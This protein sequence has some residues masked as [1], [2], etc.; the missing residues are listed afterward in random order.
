MTVPPLVSI[1]MPNYNHA[2][3]LPLT[4]AAVRAQDYAYTEIVFVDD[5]STDGSAAVAAQLGVTVRSTPVNGGPSLARN[6]G[7]AAAKGEILL[8]VDSDV[9]LP[10]TTVTDAVA[11]LRADPG[12]GAICGMLDA[13]PLVRD[14]LVQECRCLQAHYWRISSEGVVSFLFTAL[15][16]MRTDV[17]VEMGPFDERLRETEEVEYG[18]RLS[19]RYP[20]RLTSALHGRHRDEHRMLPLLSKVFRRCRLRVPLYARRRRS[21][22]G[23]ET[24]SRILGSVAALGA[25]VALPLIGVLAA[26]FGP[27]WLI[28]LPLPAG[29]FTGFVAGDAAMYRFVAQRRSGWFTIVFVAVQYVLNVAIAA[30]AAAG[31]V[32]WLFSPTFRALYNYSPQPAPRREA[33][34]AEAQ[35]AEAAVTEAQVAEVR[36]SGAAA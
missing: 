22:N 11:L 4:I 29:L 33:Q 17:F 32:Q 1:V 7:A 12:A 31:A 36:V 6:L 21:A 30:G 3:S 18:Q 14:S 2:A 28:G 35:F 34:V 25:L 16:A 9:E 26:V 10:P 5:C 23:F 20:I 27:L 15:C 24:P 8:F 19:E 13:T